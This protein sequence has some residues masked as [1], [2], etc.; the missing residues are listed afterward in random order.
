MAVG[1]QGWIWISRL[2]VTT[3]CL[4]KYYIE[5][6]VVKLNNLSL[7]EFSLWEKVIV[8]RKG[9]YHLRQIRVTAA[10]PVFIQQVFFMC[11]VWDTISRSTHIKS[12][13]STSLWCCKLIDI[14]LGDWDS[15]A[16]RSNL[17]HV[18]CNPFWGGE[19]FWR[20]IWFFFRFVY[21]D[22]NVDSLQV[23]LT[24][25][26]KSIPEEDRIMPLSS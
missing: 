18:N 10:S 24:K 9:N 1:Y 23:D 2:D 11:R 8:F 22:L 14:L 4:K 16:R 19:L 21:L 7:L 6:G 17:I 13:D 20:K 15:V 5:H 26:L 25:L 12:Q 3:K